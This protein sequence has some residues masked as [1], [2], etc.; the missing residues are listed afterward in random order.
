MGVVF[1]VTKNQAPPDNNN[2]NN[3]NKREGEKRA[4][5]KEQSFR[6]ALL[7]DRSHAEPPHGLEPSRA[8]KRFLRK[9]SYKNHGMPPRAPRALSVKRSSLRSW[10]NVL[11]VVVFTLTDRAS[12]IP[13]NICR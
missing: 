10:C 5:S 3:N 13:S 1:R 7:H 2:N 8:R 12:T 4:Q 9:V 11:V 6:K